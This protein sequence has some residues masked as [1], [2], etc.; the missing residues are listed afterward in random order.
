MFKKCNGSYDFYSEHLDWHAC[1][2]S[3]GEP[4]RAFEAYLVYRD[5]LSLDAAARALGVSP[6]QVA[7]WRRQYQ[8]DERVKVHL[9]ESSRRSRAIA[10]RVQT[11]SALS[12]LEYLHHAV[13]NE[14]LPPAERRKS[15]E[16]ILRMVGYLHFCVSDTPLLH[17]QA[18]LPLVPMKNKKLPFA[19]NIPDHRP[20]SRVA[21]KRP[22]SCT[23][24][25]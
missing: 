13:K 22:D 15:A 25:C 24:R 7:E 5:T 23:T 21:G 11:A 18:F 16:L 8:W 2:Q 12:A 4:K 19:V 1:S 14:T 20:K 17:A 3:A 6:H 10:A 9:A